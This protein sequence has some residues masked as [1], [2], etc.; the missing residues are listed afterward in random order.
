MS[1]GDTGRSA[2]GWLKLGLQSRRHETRGWL[3]KLLRSEGLLGTT[4]ADVW[5]RVMSD[6]KSQLAHL[7]GMKSYAEEMGVEFQDPRRALNMGDRNGGG[8]WVSQKR[9]SLKHVPKNALTIPYLLYAYD[10]PR[11]SF[12]RRVG[13]DK[14]GINIDR[15]DGR[16]VR[17]AKD[18]VSVIESRTAAATRYTPR[19]MFVTEHLL[20]G[21]PLGDGQTHPDRL[22]D[23]GLQFDALVESGGDISHW[24]RMSK[25]HDSKWPFIRQELIDAL[26]AQVCRSYKQLS[27]Y[28]NGWCS[29]R[30]IERWLNSHPS[31][32][33][34]RK[35]VKPG[36][37]EVICLH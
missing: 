4:D 8:E 12:R 14:N 6:Y 21:G 25:E 26:E 27:T 35:N 3:R 16:H 7:E 9:E 30:T 15:Y 37:T 31:F 11:S 18:F 10:V 23:L 36:L 13:A 1:A 22:K 34:Y 2:V 29:A 5:Q 20:C 19:H 33:V 28:I 17:K 32:E 24:E